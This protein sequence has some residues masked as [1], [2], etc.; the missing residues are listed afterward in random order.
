MS[1]MFLMGLRKALCS[2]FEYLGGLQAVNGQV[3]R[4]QERG[5]HARRS[6][7]CSQLQRLRRMA[8]LE[9]LHIVPLMGMDEGHNKQNIGVSCY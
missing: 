8:C 5:N 7:Q 9:G 4:G 6:R 2:I 1:T 3:S